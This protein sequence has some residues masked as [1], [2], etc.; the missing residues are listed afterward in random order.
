M[1]SHKKKREEQQ[2]NKHFIRTNNNP[3][4]P[5]SYGITNFPY[6]VLILK[7]QVLLQRLNLSLSL[8]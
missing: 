4:T 1:L 8:L 7:I 2:D 3:V 5:R 6:V